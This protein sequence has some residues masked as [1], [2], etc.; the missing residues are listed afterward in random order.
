[1][2]C[3]GSVDHF[4]A[5]IANSTLFNKHC[6]YFTAIRAMVLSETQT[7]N[8]RVYKLKV[9]KTYKGATEIARIAEFQVKIKTAESTKKNKV[10]YVTTEL[11]SA[12]CGVSL[13]RSKVYLLLGYIDGQKLTI[14]ACQWNAL[15]TEVTAQQR[16]GL[17]KNY[18]QNCVCRTQTEHCFYTPPRKCDVTIGGC[19]V[20]DSDYRVSYCKSK[21]AYCKKL[22]KECQWIIPEKPF[23]KC[24][25]D[26]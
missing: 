15:W 25:E 4:D 20:P 17:K 13:D 14:D 5:K 22:G 2:G 11:E 8:T 26:N 18:G 16:R 6:F 12:A 24:F 3:R 7:N 9:L 19:D 23:Q 21:T 10:I 1:M